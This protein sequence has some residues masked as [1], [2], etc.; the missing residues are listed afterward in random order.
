MVVHAI[1]L[2]TPETEAGRSQS[3]VQSEFRDNQGHTEK[4]CLEK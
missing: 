1:N 3:A 2:N 4:P